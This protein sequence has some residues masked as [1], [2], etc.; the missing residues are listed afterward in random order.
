M[1]DELTPASFSPLVG[2]TFEVIGDDEQPV[3]ELALDAVTQHAPV[4]GAPR[5]QPFS[6]TFL[7]PSGGHL[8][9]RTYR[10]RHTALGDHDIFLVPLGPGPDGLHQYEASFN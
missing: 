9:Q 7:G 6:L 2:T 10:L 5:A 3:F 1:A 8:P 4:P